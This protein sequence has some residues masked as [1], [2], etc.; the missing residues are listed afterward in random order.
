MKLWVYCKPLYV[1]STCFMG[2]SMSKSCFILFQRRKIGKYWN[3]FGEL[4]I[5]EKLKLDIQWKLWRFIWHPCLW[6]RRTSAN[7]D[8][9]ISATLYPFLTW[10]FL[11]FGQIKFGLTFHK[12]FDV[13]KNF[14]KLLNVSTLNFLYET[15]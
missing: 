5:Y 7:D 1:V 9:S 10:V 2:L 12:Y 13:S 14:S 6:Y 15:K 3:I 11:A 8:E 4:L